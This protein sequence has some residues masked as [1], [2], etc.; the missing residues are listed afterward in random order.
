[1]F[2]SYVL[3]LFC[4]KR[5]TSVVLRELDTAEAKDVECEAAWTE[6]AEAL[7]AKL[8]LSVPTVDESSA[9]EVTEQH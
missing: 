7:Y 6:H 5:S 8:A 4:E 2:L 9:V 1:M 3:V